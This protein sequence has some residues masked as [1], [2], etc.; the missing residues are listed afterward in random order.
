MDKPLSEKIVSKKKRRIYVAIGITAVVLILALMSLRRVLHPS[1]KRSEIRIAAVVR[2]NIENTI[3]ASGEILPEFEQVITSPISAS[4]RDVLFDAGASVKS[5]DAVILLDKSTSEAQYEK[6]KF[7]LQSKRNSIVKLKLELDKS[8]FDIKSNQQVKELKI[9]SLMASLEDAKRLFKAGGGTKED[10]EQAELDLKVAQL[11][12]QQIENEI[13]NKQQTMQVEKREA[14]LLASIQEQDLKEL[15][16]KLTLANII[17]PRAGVIT[18]V[19]KNIGASVQEGESLVRIANLDSYKLSGSISDSYLNQLETGLPVVVFINGKQF[20]ARVTS[21]NPTI[22]NGLISFEA[23]LD[24]K[25]HALYRPNMKVDIHL[26]TDS[27]QNVL[28][29]EN[30]Q[31][32]RGTNT[33]D[34]FIVKEGK[35]ERRSVS[36]GLSNFDFVELKDQVKE[37][38]R[39]IVSDMSEY[40]NAK[41]LTITE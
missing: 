23:S 13:Q 28:K 6:M 12:K 18:W 22:Q 35:A 5:G 1:V 21:I 7:E 34:V 11:E 32:F 36:I 26:V 16:R 37:G 9:N 3:P 15:E 27:R 41:T 24:E 30:G 20:R 39:I 33:Q 14:E 40:K 2:G 17:V 29:I 38:D 4:I 10:I 25:T 19:N 8:F 31:A